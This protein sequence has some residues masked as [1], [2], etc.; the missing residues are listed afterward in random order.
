MSK[1]D[2]DIRLGISKTS[3]LKAAQHEATAVGP[4]QSPRL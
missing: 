4:G 2:D 1:K 3:H